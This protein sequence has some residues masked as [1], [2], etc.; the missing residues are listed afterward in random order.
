MTLNHR[1]RGEREERWGKGLASTR[2]SGR[3]FMITGHCMR[4]LLGITNVASE[5][6]RSETTWLDN[7]SLPPRHHSRPAMLAATVTIRAHSQRQSLSHVSANSHLFTPSQNQERRAPS[8]HELPSMRLVAIGTA[9]GR[10]PAD[11]QAPRQHDKLASTAHPSPS[12]Q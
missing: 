7:S 10:A 6:K 5:G 11:L 9:T 4:N 8:S 2:G 1:C 3:E 12:N